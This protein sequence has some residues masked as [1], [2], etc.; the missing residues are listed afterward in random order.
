MRAVIDRLGPSE[1]SKVLSDLYYVPKVSEVF[2]EER[3]SYLLEHFDWRNIEPNN[4]GDRIIH[5][6]KADNRLLKREPI[7]EIDYLIKEGKQ[8]KID[9]IDL[10]DDV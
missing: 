5:T 3:D 7:E 1:T 2:M 10:T 6:A 4:N 8:K 9:L